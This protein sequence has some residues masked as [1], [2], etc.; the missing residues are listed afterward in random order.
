MRI[1]EEGYFSDFGLEILTFLRKLCK[2]CD[3]LTDKVQVYKKGVK[4]D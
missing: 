1:V 2:S 3:I 4:G